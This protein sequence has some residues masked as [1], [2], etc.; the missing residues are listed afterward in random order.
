M[1]AKNPGFTLFVAGLLALGIGSTTVIFSLF[2]AVFL[3]PLPVQKPTELVRMVQYRPKLRPFSLFPYAY[4]EALRDHST[5]LA[6]TFGE[7]GDYLDFALSDPEPPEQ[8]SVYGVTPEFFTA[9]GARALY[10][11]VLLPSDGKDRPGM[12]PAV[13]SYEFW[14]RRF[15]GDPSILGKAITL[16]GAPYTLIGILSP[17]FQPY[18]AADVWM[19][20]QADPNNTNQAHILMVSGRLPSGATLAEANSQMSV[21]GKRY[22]QTHADQL[23]NDD[24]LQVTLMQQR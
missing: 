1:L 21:I 17:R 7:A 18:P 4:Y 6:A 12:P 11:R 10:G 13:L 19:P 20:L 9:L 16:G 8:I 23:G 24:K 14:Q 15:G 2:D 3:R 22:V 5:T